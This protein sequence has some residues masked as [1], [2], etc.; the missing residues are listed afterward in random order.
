MTEKLRYKVWP[1][2]VPKT[3]EIP[4]IPLHEVL[5][6]AAKKFPNKS[7]IIYEDKKMPYREF[8]EDSDK[9]ANALSNMGLGKNDKAAIVMF[10]SPEWIKC[11]F[12]VLKT[13]ASV[14][15]LDA[16]SMSEDLLYQLEDCQPKVIITDKEV[17]ERERKT[18]EKIDVNKIVVNPV[19]NP[20]P[21]TYQLQTLLKEYSATPPNVKINPKEDVALI[22]YYAGIVG[23]TEQVLHTHYS[24][25]AMTIQPAVFL[26]IKEDDIGI[27]V[28]P[29]GH[30]FGIG[31]FL[32]AAYTG[33][34]MVL[35]KRFD[36]EEVLKAIKQ[37][38]IT[39]CIGAPP[40]FIR[41]VESPNFTKDT[42]KSVRWCV[43]GGAPLP[44]EIHNKYESLGIPM[45][46]VYGMTECPWVTSVPLNH[47]VYGSIGIPVCNVDVKIVD[48]ETGKRELGVGE[49][50][51][52]IIKS[53]STMKGYI[54]PEDTKQAIRDGWVYSGDLAKMDEN[55]MLYFMGVK[56]RMI[57]YKGYPVF[58]R[59]LEY[60]LSQHPAVKECKV[61]GVP[62]PDVGEI[63]KAYVVLKEEYREKV[64]VE[65]LMSFVN[66]KV[67][68]VKAIR[69]LEFVEKIPEQ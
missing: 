52:L 32:I 41:L 17:Y 19:E 59:D 44:K 8:D 62:K 11:F 7:F 33:G 39:N 57:K 45:L 49:T 65:E 68:P 1:E 46:Q 36:A 34:T 24:L 10:N 48:A 47:R 16:L 6:Q 9:F 61:V 66:K 54:S 20:L 53:P 38:R 15:A 51:E 23:R 43:S 21:K 22:L 55:G 42:L 64:S 27:I 40:M 50:G 4:E 12:G 63:P 37:Y 2:G 25:L 14:V 18:L 67:A 26:Q 29:L 31:L 58:P 35:V 5:R 30:I 3:V 28:L 69:E 13:G 60:F 56:K